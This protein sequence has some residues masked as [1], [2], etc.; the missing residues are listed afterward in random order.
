VKKITKGRRGGPFIILERP[1]L[2][3]YVIGVI[4]AWSH[5]EVALGRIL[6]HILHTESSVGLQMYLSLVGGAQ[7]RAVL[8][9]AA[10][11][12]LTG[13]DLSLFNVV[14]KAIKPI[15]ERRNDFAHG[16]WGIAEEL[17]DALLWDSADTDLEDYEKGLKQSGLQSDDTLVYR[18]N[19]LIRCKT[20]AQEAVMLVH[21]FGTLLYPGYHYAHDGARRTLSTLP[22]LV[23][24]GGLPTE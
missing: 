4:T 2:A 6:A 8:R 15:G 10:E 14:M 23:K 13:K 1:A 3:P 19:D 7:R 5:T 20:D 18:E 16:L 24:H 12:G 22:L 17:P 9:G 11:R 21:N